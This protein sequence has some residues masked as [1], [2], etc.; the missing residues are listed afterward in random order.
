ML[1]EL[2][3]RAIKA[4]LFADLS[5]YSRMD[6]KS[7]L[8]FSRNFY[9]GVNDEILSK[10]ADCINL[11]NTWGDAIHLI[12]NDAAKAGYLALEL[13][14]WTARFDW[15]RIGIKTV[16]QL[17]V[18]LHAGVVSKVY[19]PILETDN[20]IGRSTSKA[21]RIEPITAEGQVFVSEAF[22]AFVALRPDSGLVCEYVGTRTLPK[23][24]GELAV[25]LLS[26]KDP[27]AGEER[28]SENRAAKGNK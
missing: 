26:R 3:G 8:E 11:K 4:I 10:Y 18:A 16:P 2:D 28:I 9:S 12:L 23:N 19:D 14:S 20:Y 25:Y 6:E 24:S 5:G 7:C 13:Q 1:K 21:A 15:A 22:A 17:R 27:S